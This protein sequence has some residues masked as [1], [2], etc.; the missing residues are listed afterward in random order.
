[1]VVRSPVV[2]PLSGRLAGQGLMLLGTNAAPALPVLV[3]YQ[4]DPV[5]RA[6][7]ADILSNQNR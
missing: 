5:R 7:V 6:F 2:N 1:M 4:H 3:R